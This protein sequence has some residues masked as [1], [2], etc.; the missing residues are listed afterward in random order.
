[1]HGRMS[2][3]SE[4]AWGVRK[5]MALSNRAN[6]ELKLGMVRKAL[7]TTKEALE[8]DPTCANIVRGK[9]NIG[10][11]ADRRM[12]RVWQSCNPWKVLEWT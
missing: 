8:C 4:I 10:D 1:M 11:L 6:G 5:A 9:R 3:S 7:K 12:I 2:L